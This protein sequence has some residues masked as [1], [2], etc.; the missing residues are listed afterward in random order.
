MHF[1]PGLQIGAALLFVAIVIIAATKLTL[2]RKAEKEEKKALLSSN[3][4]DR[5]YEAH[6]TRNSGVI[7][8]GA[9]NPGVIAPGATHDAGNSLKAK[10]D[11]E[12]ETPEK[13]NAAPELVV[14]YSKDEQKKV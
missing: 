10:L 11:A 7:A 4:R 3:H 1:S 13:N 12:S 6:G 8:P 2:S 9:R 14:C 5:D